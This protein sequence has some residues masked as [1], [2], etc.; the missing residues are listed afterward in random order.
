LVELFL[1]PTYV[2]GWDGGWLTFA[3]MIDSPLRLQPPISNLHNN[4]RASIPYPCLLR[5]CVH[6]VEETTIPFCKA[7]SSHHSTSA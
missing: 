6:S 4:N 1:A 7:P 3:D 5:D 2:P